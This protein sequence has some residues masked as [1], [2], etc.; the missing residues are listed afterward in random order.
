MNLALIVSLGI[1]AQAADPLEQE[2]AEAIAADRPAPTRAPATAAL[3]NPEIS[4]IGTFSAAFRREETPPPFEAGDDPDPA[5]LGLQELE[6]TFA[7]AV[8]PYFRMRAFLALPGLDE[9]EIEEAYLET[10]ALPRGLLL[11]GGAIR[12]AFGRSNEQHLHQQDFARRPRTTALLGHD[13]LRGAGAQLSYLP[14]LPWYAAVFAELMTL[15]DGLTVVAGVEQFVDLGPR[16]SLLIGGHGATVQRDE[17]EHEGEPE[18]GEEAPP[19]E[20][21]VGGDVYLKWRPENVTST[22]AWFAVQLEYVAARPEGG[23]WTGAG[24]A[25]V[26]AQ[27]A[28]RV[29]LGARLDLVGLPG[30]E[31]LLGGAVS[32][33]FQPSEFSRLRL[34]YTR[35]ETRNDSFFLQLEGAIGAH[36]AHPF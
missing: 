22:Y 5:G 4:V 2:L 12:S 33:A 36:A 13:G 16:W 26:V 6:I 23:E 20:F 1:A 7:A 25:Q 19:R 14:P 15:G 17:D 21:L 9:L 31:L 3:L 18:P 28:R 11:K 8:D 27:V 29:R 30:D 24:Y 35:D 32:V 10:T 34:T